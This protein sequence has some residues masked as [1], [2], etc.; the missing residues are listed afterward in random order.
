MSYCLTKN[1]VQVVL[2]S[3]DAKDGAVIIVAV[4][5]LVIFVVETIV[6]VARRRMIMKAADRQKIGDK[7]MG[8][9]G[10]CER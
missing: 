2:W 3:R 10:G 7:Y 9:Y 5:F 6:S 8:C 4:F 1:I